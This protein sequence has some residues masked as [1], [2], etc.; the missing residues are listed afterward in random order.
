MSRHAF[1]GECQRKKRNAESRP[2][3]VQKINGSHKGPGCVAQ[4]ADVL[5]RAPAPTQKR[6]DTFAAAPRK[7][8]VML[9]GLVP[10]MGIINGS[11]AFATRVGFQ[12][13]PMRSALP[14]KRNSSARPFSMLG[15][16]CNGL[17]TC[18]V[19]AKWCCRC[20]GFISGIEKGGVLR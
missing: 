6:F 15:S 11:N 18:H 5:F 10:P 2:A 20:Q 13:K 9:K 1:R 19:C 12:S 8:Q 14:S 3:C 7:T 16:D 4:A 17:S